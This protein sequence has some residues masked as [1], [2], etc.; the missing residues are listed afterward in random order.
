MSPR[1]FCFRIAKIGAAP[2]IHHTAGRPRGGLLEVISVGRPGP[3]HGYHLDFLASCPREENRDSQAEEVSQPW[4]G[5]PAGEAWDPVSIL[6]RR[7]ACLQ[8]G[9][10]A[11]LALGFQPS[12]L[13]LEPTRV[14]GASRGARDP[15]S[16][17]PGST[18][19]PQTSESASAGLRVGPNNQQSGTC[20]K[21]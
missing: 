6:P 5:N 21:V 13:A 19:Q 11:K 2:C 8:P 9:E 12:Q 15:G 16:K 4:L 10:T 7:P 17:R 18:T 14:P 20:K 3:H 1:K